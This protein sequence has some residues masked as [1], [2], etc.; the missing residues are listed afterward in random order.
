M[1][2]VEIETLR[3]QDYG[4]QLLLDS[5]SLCELSNFKPVPFQN[6]VQLVSPVSK[7][8]KKTN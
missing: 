3:E 1:S 6:V 4:C 2:G 7:P 5:D 8:L